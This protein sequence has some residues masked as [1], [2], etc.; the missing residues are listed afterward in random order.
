MASFLDRGLKEEG[1]AAVLLGDTHRNSYYGPIAYR[2]MLE[3]LKAGFVLKE[4]IIKI[5][6]NCKSDARWKNRN[7]NFLLV[8]HEHLFVFHKTKRKLKYSSISFFKLE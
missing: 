5:Q 4:D 6:W 7:E 1:Y 3:F 8:M 2:V